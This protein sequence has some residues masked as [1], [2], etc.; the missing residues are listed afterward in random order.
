MQDKW[1]LF[2]EGEIEDISNLLCGCRYNKK[3]ILNI[4]ENIDIN[5]YFYRVNKEELIECII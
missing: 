5:K 3:D 2:G 4:L 1:R